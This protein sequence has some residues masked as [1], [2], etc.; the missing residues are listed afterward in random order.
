MR[1]STLSSTPC[2]ANLHTRTHVLSYTQLRWLFQMTVQAVIYALTGTVF[3]NHIVAVRV[4][5][6]SHDAARRRCNYRCTRRHSYVQSV[7]IHCASVLIPPRD[8]WHPFKL[9]RRYRQRRAGT[10]NVSRHI[11]LKASVLRAVLAYPL[12]LS[13]IPAVAFL[14]RLF[15]V[16]V[17]SQPHYLVVEPYH[18]RFR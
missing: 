12:I 8:G 5:S 6:G 18:T 10:R 17:C 13:R 9:A 3:Q 4:R 15:G 1:A 11:V 14:L 16:S 7:M 2:S